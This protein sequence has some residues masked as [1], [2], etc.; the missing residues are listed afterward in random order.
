M[1]IELVHNNF[2]YE[3]QKLTMAFFPDR[4]IVVKEGKDGSAV[5]DIS[6]T[7]VSDPEVITV[8]YSLDADTMTVSYRNEET[9]CHI[10]N[11]EPRGLDGDL[12]LSA[13][14]ALYRTLAEVTG[15]H[16]QWGILTGVRPSKLMTR[17]LDRDGPET[18]RSFFTKNL[19]V[20]P[21]KTELAIAVAKAEQAIIQESTP[22]SFSLYISI[23]FCPGRCSYCSFV[24]HS[25]ASPTA[26]KLFPEYFEK[27][28]VEIQKDAEIAS[29]AG[30]SLRS[31]YIGGGTPSTLSAEQTARLMKTITSSFSFSKCSE[32]TFEAGRPDTITAEK[33]EAAL[34]G[35][36]DRISINP[37]VMDD[38]I[39]KSVGRNH[40]VEQ[41]CQT[42]QMART[43]G[44]DNI[45]MDLIA[46]LPGCTPDIFRSSLQKVIGLE[47]DSVTVHT[48]A[49]KHASDLIPSKE[50]FSG[51]AMTAEMIDTSSHLLYN[52]G[53]SPYYMYRQARSLGNLENVGWS[54]PGKES[55]YNVYM[56]EEC[57]SVFACGAGAVTKLRSPD[58][59]AIHRVFNYKYPYEYVDRF[60]KVMEQKQE[61][62]SFYDGGRHV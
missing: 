51:G 9:G 32:F 30:L 28:L 5:S 41:I 35:G 26:K 43:I 57:H 34:E 46:G 54:K 24:S 52:N 16:P 13:G 56:M 18:A 45:N 47:P 7:E 3:M 2:R 25:I 36:A 15:I 61:I 4:P 22:D 40:T 60:E 11:T 37:Q 42:F 8:S 33:L 62:I 21:K 39:L 10:E 38:D 23:P 19:Y 20:T 31:V 17:C 6:D 58:G 55:R 50:L 48:L 44:F 53:Y 29:G 49:L 14:R 1:T 27:L 59:S 12:E